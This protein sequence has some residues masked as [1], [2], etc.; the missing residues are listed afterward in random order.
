MATNNSSFP[1]TSATPPANLSAGSSVASNSITNFKTNF[2]GGSRANRFRVTPG[3]PV[4]VNG[5]PSDTG[6]QITLI[7]SSLPSTQVNTIAVPYR[8]RNLY[9]AGDRIYSTW[10]VGIYDDPNNGNNLWRA[11][12]HWAELMDGHKTH[13]VSTN[14]NNFNFS[15]LQTTW[16][17]EL[18][19]LNDN[20]VLKTIQLYDCWPS[21][22][23]EINL[24]MAETGF[25][26]FSVTLTFDY[27]KITDNYNS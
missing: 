1:T 25:V 21:V 19:N 17:V 9:L 16:K 11:F 12:H 5:Y 6:A 24:N 20:D 4:E 10:A 27:L 13:T 26:G 23:G 15:N 2:K 8:G 14:N 3:W 7:S 18:L 22:V